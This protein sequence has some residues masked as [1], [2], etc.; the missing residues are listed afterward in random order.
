MINLFLLLF[1]FWT[2]RDASWILSWESLA[3]LNE[4]SRR[5][6]IWIVDPSKLLVCHVVVCFLPLIFFVDHYS[7][8]QGSYMCYSHW[9]TGLMEV[10]VYSLRVSVHI[11]NMNYFSWGY[12]LCSIVH[13]FFL[14]QWT[15]AYYLRS[16]KFYNEL[17][18]KKEKK[19]VRTADIGC[20]FWNFCW[21]NFWT[22]LSFVQLFPPVTICACGK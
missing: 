18:I 6:V 3:H 7:V 12:F 5:F 13:I 21:Q 1:V 4:S 16:G 11:I 2:F 9:L 10:S 19:S 8:I 22:N 14:S 17:I 20:L 15:S